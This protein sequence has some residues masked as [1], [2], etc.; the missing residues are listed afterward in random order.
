MSNTKFV[1][2]ER[3]IGAAIGATVGTGVAIAAGFSMPATVI[4][5]LVFGASGYY[6]GS[7]LEKIDEDAET[8]AKVRAATRSALELAGYSKDE[9]SKSMR[10]CANKAQIAAAD[11]TVVKA[12]LDAR[13]IK[14][15]PDKDLVKA[16]VELMKSQILKM[17]KSDD[18]DTNL[19]AVEAWLA[20]Q[21]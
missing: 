21:N 20:A 9:I 2:T 19:A 7:Q 4:S 13:G 12:D 10:I 14:A 16:N 18:R 11:A 17:P 5:A 3:A 8:A 15:K 1:S 6:I